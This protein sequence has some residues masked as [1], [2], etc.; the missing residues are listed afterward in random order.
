M[1]GWTSSPCPGVGA[2]PGLG[3]LR[4]GVAQ[5]TGVCSVS[6]LYQGRGLIIMGSHFSFKANFQALEN[7]WLGRGEMSL[8]LPAPVV[9]DQIPCPHSF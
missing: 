9:L 7:Q 1:V 4:G 8:F 6:R 3:L 5:G 2:L